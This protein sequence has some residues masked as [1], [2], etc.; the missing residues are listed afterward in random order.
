MHDFRRPRPCCTHSCLRPLE[1]LLSP[2]RDLRSSE[3]P[4]PRH[5][6]SPPPD[7]HSPG[8]N[9]IHDRG[10]L[11]TLLNQTLTYAPHHHTIAASQPCTVR[12]AQ[13]PFWWSV[14]FAIS[15]REARQFGEVSYFEVLSRTSITH[16][17]TVASSSRAIESSCAV[18]SSSPQMVP[19]HYSDLP[20]TLVRF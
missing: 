13:S 6:H 19:S 14:R 10:L 2:T 4:L 5:F 8:Q 16:R 9:N 7:R 17:L 12:R 3:K 20:K 11:M 18:T 15:L 1:P